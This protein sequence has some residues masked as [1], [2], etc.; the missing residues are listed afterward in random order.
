M[1]ELY[2]MFSLSSDFMMDF[3]FIIVRQVHLTVIHVYL[4]VGT[5]R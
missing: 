4:Y 5:Q 3:K 1:Q 2:H